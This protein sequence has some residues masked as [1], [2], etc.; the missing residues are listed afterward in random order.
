MFMT[1]AEHT[2]PLI[3]AE[4]EGP[5]HSEFSSQPSCEFESHSHWEVSKNPSCQLLRKQEPNPKQQKGNNF[6][7]FVF[8]ICSA[9]LRDWTL[10]N[11]WGNILKAWHFQWGLNTWNL[12]SV[13]NEKLSRLHQ[14]AT[15][16]LLGVGGEIWN[17]T[18]LNI[19][20]WFLLS[21]CP[22]FFCQDAYIVPALKC[23]NVTILIGILLALM[24]LA[25]HDQHCRVRP[26]TWKQFYHRSLLAKVRD[27]LCGSS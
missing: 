24:E 1:F 6:Y 14:R 23:L 4:A 10:K 5:L 12:K 18:E 21:R 11:S 3:T 26:F 25:S 19:V 16:S 2:P 9:L 13:E 27:L 17:L 8:H 22:P 7:H 15:L 20:F